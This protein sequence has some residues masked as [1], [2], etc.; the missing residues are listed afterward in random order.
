MFILLILVI[1]DDFISI[2]EH[3]KKCLKL[4]PKVFRNYFHF[5]LAALEYR[6][7]WSVSH[8]LIISN[9]LSYMPLM[10]GAYKLVPKR[11]K[12][13]RICSFGNFRKEESK[14]FF[15]WMSHLSLLYQIRLV[16]STV[17]L[18][19]YFF[20]FPYLEIKILRFSELIINQVINDWVRLILIVNSYSTDA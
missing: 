12:K 2:K 14:K 20:L 6:L 4:F 9:T 17:M 19:Y 16:M 13:P 11:K 7:K 18:V 15:R 1:I 10:Q 8:A 3:E 5:L